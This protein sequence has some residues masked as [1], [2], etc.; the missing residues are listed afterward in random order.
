MI[1]IKD[2]DGK[3]VHPSGPFT[4]ESVRAAA[5]AIDEAA[6]MLNYTTMPRD[7]GLDYPA[8]VA[9]VHKELAAAAEKLPQAVR[10]MAV[11]LGEQVEVGT[12]RENPA[13]G[14]HGGNAQAAITAHD[15]AV[16][17]VCAKAEEL[18]AALSRACS[19]VAGLEWQEEE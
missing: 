6:R 4:G 1:E 16:M 17:E 2:G 9:S 3:P 14:Q 11:W 5:H 10:Q 8:T 15:A 13:Y 19:T 12:V 7:G 18:A